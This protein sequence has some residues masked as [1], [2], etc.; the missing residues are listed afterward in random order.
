MF[1]DDAFK[2]TV[3]NQWY[4]TNVCINDAVKEEEW[5]TVS[6]IGGTLE[7]ADWLTDQNPL[8]MPIYKFDLDRWFSSQ[9][10]TKTVDV[11]M[12][13]VYRSTGTLPFAPIHEGPYDATILQLSA[14]ITVAG[15]GNIRIKY[16]PSTGLWSDYVYAWKPNYVDSLVPTVNMVTG[17]Y[18]IPWD[19]PITG[20]I[21]FEYTVYSTVLYDK[22]VTSWMEING[23]F[24]YG[25]LDSFPKDVMGTTPDSYE[26][27]GVS[28]NRVSN[29]WPFHISRPAT[30]TW[31]DE[32]RKKERYKIRL[33]QEVFYK[34]VNIVD[35]NG[36]PVDT[37]DIKKLRLRFVCDDGCLIWINGVCVCRY[38]MSDFSYHGLDPLSTTMH[39][40][41]WM[42]PETWRRRAKGGN[43]KEGVPIVLEVPI[44]NPAYPDDPAGQ[45]VNLP[46]IYETYIGP[47]NLIG[48]YPGDQQFTNRTNFFIKTNTI[49]LG[50]V[51]GGSKIRIAVALF[52]CL[53]NSTD[54]GFAME[55]DYNPDPEF[56]CPPMP[57]GPTTEKAL[58]SYDGQEWWDSY[59]EYGPTAET[60]DKYR[61]DIFSTT[62]IP[63]GGPRTIDNETGLLSNFHPIPPVWKKGR[64]AFVWGPL[65]FWDPSVPA[66]TYINYSGSDNRPHHFRKKFTINTPSGAGWEDALPQFLGIDFTADDGIVIWING[67]EVYR[68]QCL[69]GYNNTLT[70]WDRLKLMGNM[71]MGSLTPPDQP[72][73]FPDIDGDGYQDCNNGLVYRIGIHRTEGGWI[74]QGYPGYQQS[75][76]AGVGGAYTIASLDDHSVFRP[77]ENEIAVALYNSGVG[78]TDRAFG[79]RL[80]YDVPTSP[81]TEN[82]CIEWDDEW[83]YS[84]DFY[85]W[86]GYEQNITTYFRLGFSTHAPCYMEIPSPY[87]IR[88]EIVAQVEGGS[89]IFSGTLSYIPIS[90]VMEGKDGYNNYG[91]SAV[92]LNVWFTIEGVYGVNTPQHFWYDSD[93][94]QWVNYNAPLGF[95]DFDFTEINLTTGEYFFEL[96]EGTFVGNAI[97]QYTISEPDFIANSE[98]YYRVRYR[99]EKEDKYYPFEDEYQTGDTYHFKLA[100]SVND[101]R[102]WCFGVGADMRG[103]W[104]AETDPLFID[105]FW[106]AAGLNQEEFQVVCGDVVQTYAGADPPNI[107]RV[108]RGQ[109]YGFALY[110]KGQNFPVFCTLGNH[111]GEPT[112][113]KCAYSRMRYLPRGPILEYP[114]QPLNADI[115]HP[116]SSDPRSDLGFY[117]YE[118]AYW[119][120]TYYYWTWGSCLFVALDDQ[121][122]VN[123]KKGTLYGDTQMDWLEKVLAHHSSYKFK[124]IFHHRPSI[125]SDPDHPTADYHIPEFYPN[126]FWK[127]MELCKDYGV[128]AV[129]EGHARYYHMR[130][131]YEDP[132]DGTI[133]PTWFVGVK[134]GETQIPWLINFPEVP[135]DF[136]VF[137]PDAFPSILGM[138]TP[139][140]SPWILAPICA[141]VWINKYWQGYHDVWL[142]PIGTMITLQDWAVI[143]FVDVSVDTDTGGKVV[144]RYNIKSNENPGG[145][146]PNDPPNSLDFIFRN[147]P[148]MFAAHHQG[149][150]INFATIHPATAFIAYDTVA[151]RNWYQCKY[152]TQIQTPEKFDGD[153]DDWN[154]TFHIDDPRL[155]PGEMV[156][157]KVVGQHIGADRWGQGWEYGLRLARTQTDNRPW[158]WVAK[159]EEHMDVLEQRNAYVPNIVNRLRFKN[160][161]PDFY[162][163]TGDVSGAYPNVYK[164]YTEADCRE[165]WLVF[166]DIANGLLNTIPHQ[167]LA[168]G[169][170]EGETPWVGVD[171]A[172]MASR[173]R[174]AFMPGFTNGQDTSGR[175]YHYAWG[176]AAFIVL[177]GYEDQEQGG[178]YALPPRL[179]DKKKAWLV[180]TLQYYQDWGYRWKFIIDHTPIDHYAG[181]DTYWWDYGDTWED[182]PD[183]DWLK[184][185]IDKYGVQALFC[186]HTLEPN[187]RGSEIELLIGQSVLVQAQGSFGSTGQTRVRM[188]WRGGTF[189]YTH[190]MYATIEG[191]DSTGAL[192][193]EYILYA[194]TNPAEVARNTYPITR[195][196]EMATLNNAG[197]SPDNPIIKGFSF[198]VVMHKHNENDHLRHCWITTHQVG[199]GVYIDLTHYCVET[200]TEIYVDIPKGMQQLIK[201]PWIDGGLIDPVSP[202]LNIIHFTSTSGHVQAG[203]W[204]SNE[205]PNMICI[206][207]YNAK[208]R[209]KPLIRAMIGSNAEGEP[210]DNGDDSGLED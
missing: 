192:I 85:D 148:A 115:F 61:T 207:G 22:F 60:V 54:T 52:N 100:R 199:G 71:A 126:S 87:Q 9:V 38:N 14:W 56:W 120:E 173:W 149:M 7:Y 67:K 83:D 75:F 62:K 93:Q 177:S 109:Y 172:A 155:R 118:K 182:S 69:L 144:A 145:P 130:R 96:S 132:R 137:Y 23:P 185:V 46:A 86:F 152:R 196:V 166:R 70:Q 121:T 48:T 153:Y 186:G 28:Y 178:Q 77:G 181:G 151:K 19:M 101:R 110:D 210:G 209:T 103:N 57:F 81:G 41:G 98:V 50:N 40:L 180:D 157:W 193:W 191:V 44:Y 39:N 202:V 195:P 88:E 63:R 112:I 17:E 146:D 99:R 4:T 131:W 156:Y 84:D 165:R 43:P 5:D 11:G 142:H 104:Q 26:F 1:G 89:S 205:P 107:Y 147:R 197:D 198:R 65:K 2:D 66:N 127:F 183:L 124:F 21:E 138:H 204:I 13:P 16:N 162:Q 123:L 206:D 201:K 102:P 8:G 47:P 170:G 203:F 82:V 91:K 53:E 117:N 184:N 114:W 29:L 68:S 113:H 35:E 30:F 129:W 36:E 190:P 74:G 171:E 6:P 12:T 164:G 92:T 194:G 122:H 119:R 133:I 128:T 32:A 179:S 174:Q 34:E 134:F 97:F 18:D 159:S 15:V 25:K 167:G 78:G 37:K 24:G 45:N 10:I 143:E 135:Y 160:K 158:F 33:R 95:S 42:S 49:D 116:E 58:I 208:D 200:A 111:D 136:S 141:R 51:G 3:F 125:D 139:V 79:L 72:F 176:N 105:Y 76:V 27:A 73:F 64:G 106:K 154:F 59:I 80:F 94:E 90:D 189:Q 31:W 169:E 175:S 150:T 20:K 140:V 187:T 163:S 55:M 168:I 161:L 108:L 188:N